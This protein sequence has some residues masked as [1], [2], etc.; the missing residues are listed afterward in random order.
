M[1]LGFD[2]DFFFFLVFVVD[3]CC[4]TGVVLASSRLALTTG[5]TAYSAFVS[6]LFCMIAST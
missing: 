1:R 6:A 5:Y 4:W 3:G 2:F